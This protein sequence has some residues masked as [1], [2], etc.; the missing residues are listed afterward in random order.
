M[1]Y[2]FEFQLSFEQV[3]R[4]IYWYLDKTYDTSNFEPMEV[5]PLP[6]LKLRS[7]T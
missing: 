7:I 3:V 1:A 4:A 5:L 2:I 6:L